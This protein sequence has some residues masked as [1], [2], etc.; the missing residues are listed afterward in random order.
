M[1]IHVATPVGDFEADT[2]EHDPDLDGEFE[3]LSEDGERLMVNG[4]CCEIE[5]LDA[6]FTPAGWYAVAA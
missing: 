4:W 5:V 3:V 2:I 6:G 1:R